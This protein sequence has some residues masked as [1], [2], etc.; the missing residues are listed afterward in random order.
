MGRPT[1]LLLGVVTAIPAAWMVVWLGYFAY[2]FLSEGPWPAF[3]AMFV[4]M[5]AV[6]F[7]A[8]ALA[9][10]YARHAWRNERLTEEERTL[11]AVLVVALTAVTQPAYWYLHI[12]SAPAQ[13][14]PPASPA[15]AR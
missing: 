5:A 15:R 12:W 4:G 3:D 2:G 13:D 9:V 1:K 8:L 7:L 11:W 10:F 6:V 14:R